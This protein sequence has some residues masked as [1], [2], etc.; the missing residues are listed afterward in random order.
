MLFVIVFIVAIIVSVQQS[1]YTTTAG[2]GLYGGGE[3]TTSFAGL[4]NYVAVVTNER[5]WAGIGRVLLFGAFQIPVMISW[6]R[7]CSS[8]SRRSAWATSCRTRFPA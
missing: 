3:Q 4:D 6:T 5:F 1:F 7:S 8:G 2:G